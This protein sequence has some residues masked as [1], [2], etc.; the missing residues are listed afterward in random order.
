[1]LWSI[2][3]GIAIAAVYTFYINRV[4]G[5]FVKALFAAEAF[6]EESAVTLESLNIKGGGF[7][8]YSLREGTSFSETVKCTDGKYYIPEESMDKAESK[9]CGDKLSVFV[10]LAILITVFAVTLACSYMFPELFQFA[11]IQN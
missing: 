6:D 7:I 11:G 3:I 4:L 2:A 8:R 1:M 10:V 9:Y 5:T